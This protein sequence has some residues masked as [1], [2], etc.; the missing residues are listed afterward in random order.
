MAESIILTDDEL[1]ILTGKKRKNLQIQW[2]RENKFCFYTNLLG[3]PI[4][5]RSSLNQKVNIEQK[6]QQEPDFGALNG[7]EP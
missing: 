2:L 7:K 1:H 3:K 5:L 4:I 6:Q